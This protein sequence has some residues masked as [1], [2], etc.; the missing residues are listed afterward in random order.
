MILVSAG[1]V[2]A[3]GAG[4]LGGCVF[5]VA[6]ALR[7]TM[8]MIE[9]ACFIGFYFG[10]VL[11]LLSSLFCLVFFF[12]FFLCGFGFWLWWMFGLVLGVLALA[13]VEVG[14]GLMRRLG[15]LDEVRVDFAGEFCFV[16][17]GQL[18]LLQAII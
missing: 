11:S 9:I 13:F 14:E 2:S 3:V 5:G 4:W 10:G 6:H 12:N 8:A 18:V 17:G 1:Y 7:Q 15:Q 16:V